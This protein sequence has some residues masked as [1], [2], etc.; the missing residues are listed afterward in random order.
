MADLLANKY[1]ARYHDIRAYTN[2]NE[3]KLEVLAAA[4][5]T[6]ANREFSAED[7]IGVT[8]TVSRYYNLVLADNG[9]GLLN[10]AARG[11][12][13]TASGIVMALSEGV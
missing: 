12:L 5:Y 4:D 11:V 9:A 8:N 3:D 6:A 13:S 7:W 2:M 1:I 10:P